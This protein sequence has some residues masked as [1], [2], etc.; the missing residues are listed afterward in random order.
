MNGINKYVTETS[1]EILVASVENRGTRKL[2]AKAKPPPKPT[3]MLSLVS[4]PYRERKRID[5]EPGKFSQGCFE[6]SKFMIRLL[7]HDD[8]VHREDDGAVSFDDLA[9]KC[10]SKF[11]CTSQWPIEAWI[12]FL[13]KGGGAKQRFQYCLNPHFFQTC[14]SNPGIFMR[15]SRV[16]PTLQDPVLLLGDF[17]EYIYHIGNAHDMHSTI[18]GGFTPGGRSLKRESQP[19]FFTAVKPM[20][21]NQDLEEVQYDLDK[22]RIAV[23]KN[24]WRVHQQIQFLCNLKLGLQF[25]QAGSHEIILFNTLPAICFEKV[26]YMKTGEDLY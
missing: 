2:V 22:P 19:V 13:A 26:V 1:E 24:T 16:C 20:N 5:V 15:D 11:D 23:Y 17:A 4:I 3:K 8:T 9:E 25:C 14:R 18:Q 6:V 21:A 10:E 7:P 12:T